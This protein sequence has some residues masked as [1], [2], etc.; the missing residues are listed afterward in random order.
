MSR[1]VIPDRVQTTIAVCFF[2]EFISGST[3]KWARLVG[4]RKYENT[5][6]HVIGAASVTITIKH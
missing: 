5:K 2:G 4:R 1:T 6:S 3:M